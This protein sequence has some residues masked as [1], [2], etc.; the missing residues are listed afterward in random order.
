MPLNRGRPVLLNVPAIRAYAEREL[1]AHTM[2]SRNKD[3]HLGVGDKRK[4]TQAKKK[5][6]LF[7][8]K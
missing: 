1:T 8:F 5:K 4:Y 7:G 2:N 6:M 3:I